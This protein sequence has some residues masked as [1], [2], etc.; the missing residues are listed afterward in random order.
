MAT[1]HIGIGFSQEIDNEIAARNA[2]FAAKTQLNQDRIDF[3][4]VLSTIHYDPKITLPIINRILSKSKVIGTS[5]AGIILADSI[6]TRGIAILTITSDTIKFG[7]GSIQNIEDI[8]IREEGMLLGGNSIA[9]FG[10]MARQV[11]LYFIDSHTA[12][13][14][15]FLRGLQEVLGS[16]FPIVSAGSSDDFHYRNSFQIFQDQILKRS[17][18]GVVLGGHTGVGIGGRHGWRPLGKPRIINKVEGNI[19]RTIDGKKASS[20]YEEYFGQEVEELRA[21]HLGRMSILYPLGIYI[22]RSQEYLLRNAIDIRPDGS[23]V[24]QGD[25]PEEAEVHIMIGNKDACKQAATEA[26]EEAHQN[27]SG[28]EA[29]LII[30]LEGMARL[31]LLGRMASSEIQKIREVFGPKIPIIGMYSNGQV[32]PFQ[33]VERIKKPFFQNQSIVVLALS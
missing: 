13:N 23:I 30:V 5:T 16:L 21:H 1:T 9:D 4:L 32:F 33:A 7:I 19:I 17:A 11:F 20:I 3:V 12:N 8:T 14:S 10:K 2:A 6:E 31:K 24:C 28:K 29:K 27:L 18:V 15:L 25:V 22:E 26:A